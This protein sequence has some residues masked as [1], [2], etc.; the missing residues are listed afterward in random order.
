[1]E[2]FKIGDKLLVKRNFIINSSKIPLKFKITNIYQS[3]GSKYS[4]NTTWYTVSFE[5][6]SMDFHYQK[7]LI[8]FHTKQEIRNK[9]LRKITNE[10]I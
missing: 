4:L 2:N 5:G 1:M 9:K 10:K 8:Y 7:M 3:H 6:G